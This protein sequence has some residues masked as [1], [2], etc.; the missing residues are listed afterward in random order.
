MANKFINRNKALEHSNNAYRKDNLIPIEKYPDIRKPSGVEPK[1]FRK[2]LRV[3]TIME[4]RLQR[5]NTRVNKWD[6]YK[7]HTYKKYR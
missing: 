4:N 7:I 6:M 2:T 5:T 1:T 3:K